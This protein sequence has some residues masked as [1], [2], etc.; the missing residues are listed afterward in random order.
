MIHSDEK[1][2]HIADKLITYLR[3][4]LNDATLA[5]DSPLTQLKGGL[6]T[7]TYQFQLKGVK[8]R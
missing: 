3:S 5:Y 7:A 1:S 6:E 4:E 2:S 8:N